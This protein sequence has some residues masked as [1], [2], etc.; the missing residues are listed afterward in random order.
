MYTIPVD[1]SLDLHTFRPA[2]APSLVDEYLRAAQE[3]GLVTVRIIHGKG[4]GRLKA[5]VHAV[6]AEHP[7]VASFGNAPDYLGGWGATVITLHGVGAAPAPRDSRSAGAPPGPDSLG[8]APPARNPRPR[9][10]RWT[11]AYLRFSPLV[12]VAAGILMTLRMRTDYDLVRWLLIAV[13]VGLAGWAAERRVRRLGALSGFASRLLFTNICWFVLP[14]YLR[15]ASWSAP[16]HVLSVGLLGALTLTWEV[17]KAGRRV[18]SLPAGRAA[19]RALTLFYLLNMALP[20]VATASLDMAWWGAAAASAALFLAAGFRQFARPW[21]LRAAALAG[22]VL[23]AV[24]W[25]PWFPPVPMW[26]A[27]AQW[28][29][30]AAGAPPGPLTL[31]TGIVAP[32]GLREHLEHVWRHDGRITDRVP[33]EIAGGRREGFR[34]RSRKRN[35]PAGAGGTWRVDVRTTSGRLLGTVAY[36]AR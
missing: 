31:H 28:E 25:R 34:T 32:Q 5:A 22:I 18:E 15:S 17:S 26:L 12:S 7:R 20:T 21:A 2:D 35:W 8:A 6:L 16:G 1:D 14:F 9:R 30:D 13:G 4:T 29:T 23:L 19:M 11:Q 3:A 27:D 24:L 36:Q 10:A 33:L